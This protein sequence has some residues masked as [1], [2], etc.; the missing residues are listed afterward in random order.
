MLK[1]FFTPVEYAKPNPKPVPNI[2]LRGHDFPINSWKA[3]GIISNFKD[4]VKTGIAQQTADKIFALMLPNFVEQASPE[5]MKTLK[6]AIRNYELGIQTLGISDP[7]Q[8]V[9][10]RMKFMCGEDDISSER[11]FRFFQKFYSNL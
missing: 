10:E 2:F 5:E 6:L 4:S 9:L 8:F 3:R 1:R 7:R 11:V